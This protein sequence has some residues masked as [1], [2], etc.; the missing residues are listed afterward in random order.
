MLMYSRR[1]AAHCLYS[2]SVGFQESKLFFYL[3]KFCCPVAYFLTILV[4]IIVMIYANWN[5][6]DFTASVITNLT[7][8]TATHTATTQHW[9]EAIKV[10]RKRKTYYK[11][12][13]F[14]LLL[15]LIADAMACLADV[16]VLLAIKNEMQTL[17]TGGIESTRTIPAPGS[18]T[19]TR[20]G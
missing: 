13:V 19:T 3:T 12:N 2:S 5:G 7:T 11:V 20:P 18:S 8:N 1:G 9:S 14:F 4:M 15:L 6:V 10:H 16:F 17:S